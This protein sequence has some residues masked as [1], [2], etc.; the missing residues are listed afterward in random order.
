MN[1]SSHAETDD[2]D[3][4]T[5]QTCWNW[6][7]WSYHIPGMLKQ[8]ILTMTHSRHARTDN[9]DHDIFQPC[10]SDTDTFSVRQEKRASTHTHPIL[11]PIPHPIWCCSVA[12]AV[13]VSRHLML[14]PKK[15]VH[16]FGDMGRL[17]SDEKSDRES[18]GD[19]ICMQIGRRIGCKNVRVDG[20]LVCQCLKI[21]INKKL[22]NVLHF[23]HK[24][25]F[26]FGN[27]FTL[28]SKYI[29]FSSQFRVIFELSAWDM[30]YAPI[31]LVF[32]YICIFLVLMHF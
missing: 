24:M 13:C 20:P 17:V 6:W 11:H 9:F 19:P 3:N 28:H 23:G 32:N 7:L 26:N 27:F 4:D 8:T 5:F 16:N 31:N 15:V 12:L 10:K 22:K 1:H 25:Q 29:T 14:P 18:D 21:Y 2:F 30:G